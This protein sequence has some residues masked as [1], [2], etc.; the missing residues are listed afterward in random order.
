MPDNIIEH[1]KLRDIVTQDG[2]I[3]CESQTGMYGLPQAGIIVQ[4]LLADHLRQHGY[5]QREMPPGLWS[6]KM[7][8]IRFSLIVDDFR[9]KYVRKENAL[10]LLNTIQ[11]YYKC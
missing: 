9:V 5:T 1:Y 7:H 6:H 3:Y 11:K 8:L 2:H 10:H 4:E